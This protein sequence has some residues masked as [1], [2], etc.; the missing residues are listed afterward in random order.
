MEFIAAPTV[1]HQLLEHPKDA[2]FLYDLVAEAVKW[3]LNLPVPPSGQLGSVGGGLAR[4]TIFPDNIAPLAF[5]SV[6]ALQKYFNEVRTLETASH[7][8]A[9]H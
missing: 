5:E 7:F 8:A 3:L 2:E 6:G 4:H 9:Q 1:W